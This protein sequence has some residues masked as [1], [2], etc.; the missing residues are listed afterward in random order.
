MTSAVIKGM[1]ACGYEEIGMTP[2]LR[3]QKYIADC[4]ITSR[5]KA[6]TL[7]VGGRVRLNGK[8][9]T[10]LGTKLN[11]CED[12]VAIDGKIIHRE[13]VDQLYILLNKPRGVM[14]TLHDPEGRK[15][16]ID[17]IPAIKERV[18]PVGR[19]DYHSE[20]L[21]LLTNDGEFAHKVMH[22]SFEVVKVYEVKVFG[23]ITAKLLRELKRERFFPEGA[24]RPLSV[25]VIRQLPNKTWLEF[26]LTE[27][28]NREIRRI[29][30]AAGLTIDKLRRVAIGELSIQGVAPGEFVFL[31][32]KDL[33][34][35]LGLGRRGPQ[36]FVSKKR[37]VNIQEKRLQETRTADSPYYL[38]Y[39]KKNYQKTFISK[40]RKNKLS[41]LLVVKDNSFTL[42]QI[43]GN[44]LHAELKSLSGV[45]YIGVVFFLLSLGK[46]CLFDKSGE[47]SHGLICSFKVFR[48]VARG[49]GMKQDSIDVADKSSL[50]V[51]RDLKCRVLG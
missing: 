26:R 11:P 46:V 34:T 32:K 22:P 9:V 1:F 39:R 33:E 25:R 13:S 30:E 2:T 3:L 16:V 5:R 10:E 48:F 47:H 40:I 19:L 43:V 14:T 45:G 29:C 6:E 27:G 8:V 37:T 49:D 15:T 51:G 42:G 36:K 4:G 44:S 28:R 17:L 35:Q 38:Q 31:N 18:F 21:L 12:V 7:I 24:V 50:G 23:A 41:K 20:G